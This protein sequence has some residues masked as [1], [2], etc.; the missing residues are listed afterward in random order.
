MLNY[1]D[2]TLREGLREALVYLAKTD[3]FMKLQTEGR[4]MGK[5]LYPS[6]KDPRGRPRAASLSKKRIT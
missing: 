4:G 6:P 2:E 3:L 1:Y 5:G